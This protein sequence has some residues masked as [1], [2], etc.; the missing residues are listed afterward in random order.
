MKV[1]NWQTI[2]IR[3]KHLHAFSPANNNRKE[4]FDVPVRLIL[5]WATFVFSRVPPY[6]TVYIIGYVRG[7]DTRV[8]RVCNIQTWCSP[9]TPYVLPQNS[10]CFWAKHGMILSQTLLIYESRLFYT[11]ISYRNEPPK[12]V[13]SVILSRLCHCWKSTIFAAR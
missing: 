10:L 4:K 11:E 7:W 12:V 2:T 8:S 1:S 9:K 3:G 5:W 6:A 13:K